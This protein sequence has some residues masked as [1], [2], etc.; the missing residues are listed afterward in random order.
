MRLMAEQR[1]P[2][3]PNNF[4]IWFKYALGTSS[5]LKRTI[6]ILIGNKR[7]FD[8]ETNHDLFA[9]YIGSQVVAEDAVIHNVSQQLHSVMDVRQAV[10]DHGDCRQPHAYAGHQ[11]CR[12]PDRGRRRSEILVESLMSEL[13]KAAA[14]AAKL[15]VSFAE[16][17]RELDAIRDFPEQVG[18]ARQDRHAHGPAEPPR[19]R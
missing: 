4:H 14:R 7:K 13:A 3:T 18:G 9:T 6:D 5:D 17:S 10:S 19:A 16:K 1:V 12:R 2:P 11:R 15:E 8:A